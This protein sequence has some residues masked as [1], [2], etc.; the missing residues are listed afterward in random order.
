MSYIFGQRKVFLKKLIANNSASLTFTGM[1]SAYPYY[2]MVCDGIILSDINRYLAMRYSNDNGAT[3]ITSNY[4]WTTNGIG[5]SSYDQKSADKFSDA[6]GVI[7][8]SNDLATL[9]VDINLFNMGVAKHASFLAIGSQ[10]TYYNE[11]AFCNHSAG[12]NLSN[13]GIN[14]IKLSACNEWGDP[15]NISS[16]TFTLYGVQAM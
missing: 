7:G 3:W 9:H 8:R 11:H 10:I 16:G 12:G 2:Y 13:T 14:A 4:L 15:Y 1:T 6:L 5:Y